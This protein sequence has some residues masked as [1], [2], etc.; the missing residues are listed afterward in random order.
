MNDTLDTHNKKN[1]YNNNLTS[2]IKLPLTSGEEK[3]EHLKNKCLQIN[4]YYWKSWHFA[5]W[6]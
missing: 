2:G 6:S 4:V 1:I 5:D 3:E